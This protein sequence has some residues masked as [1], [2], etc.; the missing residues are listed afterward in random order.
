M[1]SSDR[2]KDAGAR[3]KKA[4]PRTSG[5]NAT[6]FASGDEARYVSGASS[7]THSARWFDWAGERFRPT[8]LVTLAPVLDHGRGRSRWDGW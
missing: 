4:R 1:E 3:G 7:L 8:R 2:T 6:A 5:R